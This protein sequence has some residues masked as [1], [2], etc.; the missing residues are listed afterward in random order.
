MRSTGVDG[1]GSCDYEQ[2]SCPE[3]V[4]RKRLR[5]KKRKGPIDVLM[6]GPLHGLRLFD[7]DIDGYDKFSGGS[8]IDKRVTTK[9]RPKVSTAGDVG[10]WIV[11]LI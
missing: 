1:S 9:A 8:W 2:F 10:R 5:A 3:S 11:F 6:I 7:A 4:H